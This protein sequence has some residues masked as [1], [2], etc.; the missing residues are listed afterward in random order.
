MLGQ[1]MAKLPAHIIEEKN[2]REK[3][4]RREQER[5]RIDIPT[6]PDQE[7]TPD[8]NKKPDGGTV[9]IINPDGSE[10]RG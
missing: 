4:K 10:K 8:P 5:P 7:K 1:E 6:P 3:R 2:K 9:I